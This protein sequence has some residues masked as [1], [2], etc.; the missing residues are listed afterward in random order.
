MGTA[1]VINS[2]EGWRLFH[3]I[4]MDLTKY[5]GLVINGSTTD[6]KLQ[7]EFCNILFDDECGFKENFI[8]VKTTEEFLNV[9]KSFG[10]LI[11]VGII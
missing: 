10:R 1:V 4:D 6:E 2:T 11:F 8:E 5:D 7:D 3:C 9:I